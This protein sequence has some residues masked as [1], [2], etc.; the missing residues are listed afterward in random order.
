M[1]DDA[2]AQDSGGTYE[3]ESEKR[4]EEDLHEEARAREIVQEMLDNYSLA[5]SVYSEQI[6]RENDDLSF[7]AVHMWTGDALTARAPTRDP[8]TGTM[9][10]ERPAL[11]IHL[12]DQPLQQI[13]SEARQASLSLTVKPK[14]GLANTKDA[15]L[16]KGIVRAIQVESGATAVR[17]WALERASRCGR[18]FYRI[19][20]VFA[21]D[22][23]YDQDLRVKRIL[24][25]GNVYFDPSAREADFSD[26][27][28][29]IELDWVTEREYARRWPGA[30]D[31]PPNAFGDTNQPWYSVNTSTK[32]NQYQIARYHRVVHERKKLAHHDTAGTRLLEEMPDD[33]KK[34]EEMDD[35][36]VRVRVIDDRRIEEFLIDGTQIL[37]RTDWE[38]RYLPVIPVVGKE[39]VVKGERIWKGLIYNA[40]DICRAI[41]VLVSASIEVAGQMPR[42]P[43]IMAHGQDEGYEPMWDDAFTKSYTRMIYRPVTHEGQI[44]PPPQRQNNEPQIQG[45]M[46]LARMLQDMFQSIVGMVDPSTRAI[47]PRDR[48]GRAIE[49]LQRQGAAGTSNYLDGLGTISMPAEGRALVNLIAPVYDRP[50]RIL[51]VLGE[52][53]D[54]ETAIMIKRPFI[55]DDEGEPI[56]VPCQTCGGTG[57]VDGRAPAV[58]G[59]AVP[60]VRTSQVCSDCDGGKWATNDTMP[61][62]WNGKKVDYVDFSGAEYKVQVT[63]GKSFKTKQDEALAGLSEIAKAVPQL[64]PSFAD[65]WVRA[66]GFSGSQEVADRIERL[67]P[68]AGE[69]VEDEDLPPELA[70]R[71]AAMQEQQKALVQQLEEAKRAL[72]T[73]A[74]KAA[75]DKEIALIKNAQAELVERVRQEGRKIQEQE[76]VEG[77]AAIESLKGAIESMQQEAQRKHEVLLEILEARHAEALKRT[78]PAQAPP[79]PSGS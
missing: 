10:A 64:V 16:L 40:R 60:G 38:G 55:R 31:A 13:A 54:D 30:R 5:A 74:I 19:D 21:N 33:I 11:Q 48:S 72:S 39:Y 77:S 56:A 37:E 52:E 59:S 15:T 1:P 32:L 35:P 17:I 36:S 62:Q 71:F 65:L 57:K 79:G 78:A 4:S 7:D 47:N 42:S 20:K 53:N 58:P 66:L 23:D 73:N 9:S 14:A 8:D 76:K 61:E 67:N 22:G 43:W 51:R 68:H 3:P 75:S 26:A 41:N 70:A 18:G 34:L 2:Y 24:D 27:E 45:L 69:D 6:K 44:A 46:F 28:W 29:V 49:A 63:V 50:G 25:Q 12:L